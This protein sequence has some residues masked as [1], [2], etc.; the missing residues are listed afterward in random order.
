MVQIKIDRILNRTGYFLR[1]TGLQ[2]LDKH[3]AEREHNWIILEQCISDCFSLRCFKS[4]QLYVTSQENVVCLH[5][6]LPK[7]LRCI[8]L[9]ASEYIDRMILV[10]VCIHNLHFLLRHSG[11]GDIHESVALKNRAPKSNFSKV[12]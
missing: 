2:K 12:A 10:I 6:F 4:K 8:V 5:V 3:T 9:S 11:C 1:E 7:H